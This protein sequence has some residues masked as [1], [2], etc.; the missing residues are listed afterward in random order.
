MLVLEGHAVGAGATWQHHCK[1]SLLQGTKLSE[2]VAK[3]GSKVARH[4]VDGNRE[5]QER[6]LRHC[7]NHGIAV[8]R[9]DAYTYTQS[10]NGIPAARGELDAARSAGLAVQWVDDAG[11]PFPYLGGAC[12]CA[13][14]RSST[15][16]RC[17]TAS[18]P[19]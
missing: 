3:H 1:I 16:C 8:Q 19:N 12:D 15:R 4:Y 17:W 9:E 2:L 11:V 14:R 6:V 10:N 7:E 13:I 5:G 18:L